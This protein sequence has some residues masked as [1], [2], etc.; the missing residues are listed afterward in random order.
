MLCTLDDTAISLRIDEIERRGP[1]TWVTGRVGNGKRA[2]KRLAVGA[3][4]DFG[5]GAP[6]W[7]GVGNAL[8]QMS[9]RM[10]N[11]PWTH[12]EAPPAPTPLAQAAPSNLRA[13]VEG[14]I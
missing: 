7:H 6:D 12:G 8:A 4:L 3:V 5:P 14:L 13:A 1:F 2:A 11:T 10:E 9:T